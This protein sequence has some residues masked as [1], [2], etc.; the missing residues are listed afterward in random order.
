MAEEF[1]LAEVQ[2]AVTAAMT[3]ASAAAGLAAS[4]KIYGAVL[5]D[6]V[7]TLEAADSSS[8]PQ[9]AEK[10]A[11]VVA[12]WL[13]WADLEKKKKQWKAAAKTYDLA[14]TCPIGSKQAAIWTSYAE[15]CVERN[16]LTNA[17]NKY[18]SALAAVRAPAMLEQVLASYLAFKQGAGGE[19]GLTLEALRAEVLPNSKGPAAGE[20]QFEKVESP[21][22]QLQ[23]KLAA[24]EREGAVIDV[25]AAPPAPTSSSSSEVATAV[26]A[27]A[28]SVTS[29]SS[30]PPPP[31]PASESLE[32][33]AMPDADAE[34]DA[35]RKRKRAEDGAEV[36]GG[37]AAGTEAAGAGEVDLRL[38]KKEKLE[39][40]AAA[41]AAEA[42]EAG[43]G[44]DDMSEDEEEEEGSM[45]TMLFDFSGT[46]VT[47]DLPF[48]T[49]DPAV[50]ADLEELLASPQAA[51]VL[52]IV[53]A[54]RLLQQLKKAELDDAWNLLVTGRGGARGGPE[55]Q[56]A[57]QRR[58]Q[59]RNMKEL[60][61]LRATQLAILAKA[62]IPLFTEESGGS[63]GGDSCCSSSS[64][65]SSSTGIARPKKKAIARQCGVVRA[66]LVRKAQ[67]ER[68]AQVASQ[69]PPPH[70]QY[71][72]QEHVAPPP[73]AR[74]AKAPPAKKKDTAKLLALLQ[75]AKAK[76]KGGLK[77]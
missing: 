15:W 9:R 59:E 2:A 42:A 73:A 13:A 77:K 36:D 24:A 69:Q 38:V 31:P 39:D 22:A 45:P 37:E 41:E 25:E 35:Q 18:N 57:L 74:P 8:S 6:W 71:S 33:A 17:T 49:H 32:V 48:E 4:R 67:L 7:K 72:Y 11:A 61:E 47:W 51:A 54:M 26:D 64:S 30:E 65:S 28:A 29:S 12:L 68:R 3:G 70:Q 52:D 53:E 34:A 5:D 76:K 63:S 46:P 14:T 58:L 21:E 50:T 56:Q 1:D 66:I 62:G 44:D 75:G 27:A 19:P 20:V 55:V 23:S 40:S 43:G 16:K 10:E 60:A